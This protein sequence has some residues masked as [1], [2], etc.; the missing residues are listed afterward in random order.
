M[1]TLGNISPAKGSNK[2]KKRVGRG[3]G[4]TGK[5]SGRGHGGMKK[6]RG[7][8]VNVGFEGG[9][10]PLYRRLPKR[11]FHNHFRVEYDQVNLDQLKVFDG[12]QT[13]TP[14]L[15]HKAGLIRKA[16]NPVKVLGRG[17]LEK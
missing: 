13:V 11:G 4:S 2:G 3:I 8:L 17:K 6:R 10:M 16:S 15:L 12:K 14:E 1:K 5:T 9:Q 7:A